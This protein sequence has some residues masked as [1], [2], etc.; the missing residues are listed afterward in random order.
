MLKIGIIGCGT[1]GSKLTRTIVE[2]FSETSC[3]IGI[4]DID[5]NK[6]EILANSINPSPPILSQE[7]LINS[8]D[9]IIESASKEVCAKIARIVISKSKDIMVMS[10]GGLIDSLDLFE[11]AKIKSCHIYVPSGAIC[12]LDGV[13]SAFIGGIK[14]VVLTTRKPPLSLNDAPYIAKNK[15]D[16]F[17]IKGEKIIFEGSAREAIEGF[18]QNIN[19]SVILSLAGIGVDKTRVRIITSPDYKLNIHEIEVD[20]EFGKLA[21]RT[22][23]IPSPDNPK[24][25]FMAILSAI[26]TL[27]GILSN[28]RIGT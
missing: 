7:E 26:A 25:S 14:S 23:N 20:G 4:N 15:I 21:T 22:E 10:A 17:G 8:A 6:S 5:K 12:G 27:K 19:V 28:V 16:L 9:L 13:K 3:L 2:D 18:P 24:T 1:I 11:E